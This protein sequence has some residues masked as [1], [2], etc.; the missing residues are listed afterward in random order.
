MRRSVIVLGV[1]VGVGVG[2]WVGG[3]GWVC[4]SVCLFGRFLPLCLKKNQKGTPY[5]SAP[6]IGKVFKKA[7]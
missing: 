1:G 7:F 2:V 5:E 4:L 6:Y 3:C